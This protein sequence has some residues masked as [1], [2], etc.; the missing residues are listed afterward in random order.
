MLAVPQLATRGLV[1]ERRRLQ[2]LPRRL[3]F[4]IT[5]LLPEKSNY[6]EAEPIGAQQPWLVAKKSSF[7]VAFKVSDAP[8]I[9]GCIDGSSVE[10]TAGPAPGSE[11][12]ITRSKNGCTGQTLDLS[13]T[14]ETLSGTL[15]V[16]AHFH[17]LLTQRGI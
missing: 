4:E 14:T 2:R 1:V 16:A 8:V 9:P 13:E 12:D 15:V 7:H 11:A 5:S 6:R 3:F 17:N 10:T